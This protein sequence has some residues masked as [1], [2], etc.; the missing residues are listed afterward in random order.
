MESLALELEKANIDQELAVTLQIEFASFYTDV[1]VVQKEA[2]ALIVT[3]E[4]QTETMETAKNMR[5]ALKKTRVNADKKRIKLKERSKREGDAIQLVGN[6]VRDL[7][8]PL[9]VHLQLQEDFVKIKEAEKKGLLIASRGKELRGIGVAEQDIVCYNLGSM[10]EDAY[11][12]ILSTWTKTFETKRENERL[13]REEHTAWENKVRREQEATKLENAELKERLAGEKKQAEKIR[14][15]Q[16][17]KS[18]REAEAKQAE[19]S[20]VAEAEAMI[21]AKKAEANADDKHKLLLLAGQIGEIGFPEVSD[22][23]A[24]TILQQVIGRL[25]NAENFI[26]KE[27]VNL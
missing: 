23:N 21:A 4:S 25:K 11:C 27:C 6:M 19:E 16:K 8:I 15:L 24:K 20:A 13:A 18:D 14:T 5:L 26:V 7:I 10:T 3:E 2:M 9:E 1:V 17:E 22:P 12:G